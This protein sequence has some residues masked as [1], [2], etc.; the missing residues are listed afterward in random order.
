MN[1]TPD[2]SHTTDAHFR[3]VHD[4][5]RAEQ[6]ARLVET[7][8]FDACICDGKVRK[9]RPNCWATTHNLKVAK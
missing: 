4:K 7:I 3:A 1:Q 2:M 8:P 6:R 9:P 5:V